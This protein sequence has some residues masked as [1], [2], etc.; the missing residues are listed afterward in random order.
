MSDHQSNTWNSEQAVRRLFDLHYSSLSYF[1]ESM[2]GNR[3]VSEDIA[4][5]AFMKFLRNSNNFDSP[6]A[7]R[8][9]LFTTVRNACIDH[10]RSEKRHESAHQEIEHL[11]QQSTEEDHKAITAMLLQAVYEEVE[12]LPAQC[13]TVFRKL[14]YD[15]K[16]TAVVA[17]ELGI[18]PQTVLNQK[19]KAI[20]HLQ[21]FL[22]QKGHL[23]SMIFFAVMQAVLAE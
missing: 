9:F 11:Q 19:A 15:G 12:N 17:A 23:D 8:A 10:M 2:T 3:P 20:R 6:E 21:H 18:S 1:A 22:Q 13:R 7:V 5:E 16:K 4:L 14:F